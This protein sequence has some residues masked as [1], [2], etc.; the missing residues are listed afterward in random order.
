MT[1][2]ETPA[3]WH[4]VGIYFNQ[5]WY[6]DYAD[7]CTAIDAFIT[8]SDDLVPLLPDEIERV[9]ARYPT[10][11][12][13]KSY[14]DAEGAQYLPPADLGGYRGWMERT[15]ARVRAALSA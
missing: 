8:E 15:A 2:G 3:L 6:V 9:L 10:E 7:E 11:V 14:L 4:F 12:E 5:D 1:N 13:L